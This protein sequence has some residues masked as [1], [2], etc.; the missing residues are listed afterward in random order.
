MGLILST[1]MNGYQVKADIHSD[2]EYYLYDY[3]GETYYSAPLYEKVNMIDANDFTQ[4]GVRLDKIT[5]IFYDQNKYYLLPG[6]EK[7]TELHELHRYYLK[8][9][10]ETVDFE[11]EFKTELQSMIE[12]ENIVF[13]GNILTFTYKSNEYKFYISEEKKANVI[14]NLKEN[15]Q[16][17]DYLEYEVEY[18]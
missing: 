4:E 8:N 18:G 7:P 2:S 3:W 9:A 14:C 16:I 12:A 11:E 17:G 15:V 1:M 6:Y 13:D 10:S 5:D